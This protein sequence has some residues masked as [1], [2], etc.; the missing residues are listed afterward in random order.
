MKQVLNDYEVII[1]SSAWTSYDSRSESFLPSFFKTV[2]VLRR[3]KKLVILLGK[4][5]H[6][7]G[8]D[9]ICREKSISIPHIKCDDHEK[10]KL[11][12]NIEIMNKR[13]RNLASTIEGVEYF[14]IV[15]Y[16]CSDG[17]CSAYDSNGEPLYYDSS[18]LSMHAS[19]KIGKEIVYRLSG[20]P[21]PFTL[22]NEKYLNSNK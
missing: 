6:I 5:P 19:W 11:A 9:R 4:I 17:L 20:V 21:Y 18:H 10:T 16:I 13:L 14:D 12:E 1:I 8:Y 7:D 2:E 3:N 22:I 15:D